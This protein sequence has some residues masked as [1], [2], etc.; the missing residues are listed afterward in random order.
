MTNS[1]A[2]ITTTLTLE[3]IRDLL[4]GFAAAIELDQIRV[5]ALPSRKFHPV[6]GGGMW[7]R[8]RNDHIDFINRLLPT[9][10]AIP[11]AL[12]QELA[13]LA[14]T[15]QTSVVR[16]AIVDLFA[17]AA[18][19]MCLAL[20]FESAS[21]FLGWLIKNVSR[22]APGESLSGDVRSLTTSSYR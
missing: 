21:L 8:Y 14:I 13:S 1:R 10:N 9:V 4:T 18:T 16:E 12:L 17:D 20:E 7:P 15:Y 6:Y 11:S 19:G 5:D 22:S 2:K 3:D